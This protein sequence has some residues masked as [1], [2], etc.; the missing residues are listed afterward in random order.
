MKSNVSYKNSCP[1]NPMQNLAVTTLIRLHCFLVNLYLVNGIDRKEC[2]PIALLIMKT[3]LFIS[4]T[5]IWFWL[6]I[7][8]DFKIWLIFWYLLL[9]KNRFFELL[10]FPVCIL[11][12]VWGWFW[13]S[14][15]INILMNYRCWILGYY[16]MVAKV[17]SLQR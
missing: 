5:A 12:G 17:K 11:N 14:N 10:H 6:D 15:E 13:I 4:I 1:L 3:K 7:D 2:G 9:F 16:W 8:F